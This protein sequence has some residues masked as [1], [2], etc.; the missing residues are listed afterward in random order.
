L[1]LKLVEIIISRGDAKIGNREIHESFKPQHITDRSL[2]VSRMKKETKYPML[3]H[4]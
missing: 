4:D 3:K 2:T 1:V